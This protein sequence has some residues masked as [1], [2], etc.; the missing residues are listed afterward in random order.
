MGKRPPVYTFQRPRKRVVSPPQQS[1][2]MESYTL[3]DEDA[4]ND[5]DQTMRYTRYTFF[6][7]LLMFLMSVVGMIYVYMKGVPVKIRP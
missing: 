1:P 3:V 5:I 6:I 7:V 2:Q 4:E